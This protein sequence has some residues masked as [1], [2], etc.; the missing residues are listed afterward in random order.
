MLD[1]VAY[2]LEDIGMRACTICHLPNSQGLMQNVPVAGLPVDYFLRQLDELASG[3][4]KTSDTHKANG[5]E[6]AAMARA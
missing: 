5:F 2:G 3:D 4:R 6:M 1:I